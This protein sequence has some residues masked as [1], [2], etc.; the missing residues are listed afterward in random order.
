M[1]VRLKFPILSKLKKKLGLVTVIK[2]RS[3]IMRIVNPT[4]IEII[5]RVSVTGFGVDLKYLVLTS[6]PLDQES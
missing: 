3:V 2:I 6:S 4:L 1:Y 5:N